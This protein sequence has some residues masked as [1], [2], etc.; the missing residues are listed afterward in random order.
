MLM[1]YFLLQN[2]PAIIT[3]IGLL[4][5]EGRMPDYSKEIFSLFNGKNTLNRTI[6]TLQNCDI[7]IS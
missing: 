7:Q 1:K 3:F 5:H 6:I 2:Y 4:S